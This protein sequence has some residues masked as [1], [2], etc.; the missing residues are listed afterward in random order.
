MA[1]NPSTERLIGIDNR[2]FQ[3]I[4]IQSDFRTERK[5][6]RFRLLHHP[7][8]RSLS[9]KIGLIAAPNIGMGTYKPALLNVGE[10]A[11]RRDDR[12]RIFRVANG[13]RVWE[14]S[15]CGAHRWQGRDSRS[16]LG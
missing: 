9:K 13:P 5:S 2:R 8:Q 6:V 7:A 3:S 15:R 1:Y 10:R 14:R 12:V 4:S 11:R 16:G